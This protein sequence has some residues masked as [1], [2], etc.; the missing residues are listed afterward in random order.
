MDPWFQI[1]NA[2]DYH[3]EKQKI[4]TKLLAYARR[5]YPK[6]GQRAVLMEVGTPRTYAKFTKRP[7][8]MVGGYRL[9]M[10][11]STSCLCFF[12]WVVFSGGVGLFAFCCSH[13]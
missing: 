6:L 3:N 11:N 5:V 9:D 12:V 1:N 10:R 4:A 7:K 13:S 2:E 8:G